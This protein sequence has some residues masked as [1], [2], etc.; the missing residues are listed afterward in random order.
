MTRIHCLQT[1]VV[2]ERAGERGV[3][4]YLD[5]QWREQALPVNAFLVEHSAGLCLFDAGQVTCATEQ[6]HFPRWQP[7]FRLSKFE[8]APEEEVSARLRSLDLDPTAVRW[9]VV[10]HLHTDHVGDLGSFRYSEVLV[11]EAQWREAHGL[12]GRIRGYVPQHWPAGLEPRL[13]RLDA[14]GFGPFPASHDL[15]GDGTLVAV[16]IPAHAAGHLGLLVRRENGDV[17]LGG[18]A[19]HT[20]AELASSAPEIAR[21]C[22]EHRISV[23]LA[24]DPKASELV[25]GRGS[26]FEAVS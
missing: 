4:R 7:F 20:T 15:A 12:R 10:S 1:G 5:A 13:L 3:R 21:Y 22:A 14:G 8:L 11:S 25:V 2:R 16:S 23:A 26:R 18:D 9:V 19:A 24:H 6:G 17:L